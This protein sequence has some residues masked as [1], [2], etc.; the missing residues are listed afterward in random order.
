MNTSQKPQD[1]AGRAYERQ[2]ARALVMLLQGT[3]PDAVKSVR[4]NQV[5]PGASGAGHEI[6]LMLEWERQGKK[7]RCAVECKDHGRAVEKKEVGAFRSVLQDVN[8]W[9]E[10]HLLPPLG[11]IMASRNG[12]QSGAVELADYSEMVLLDIHAPGGKEWKQYLKAFRRAAGEEGEPVPKEMEISVRT[13]ERIRIEP[14]GED[15][16]KDPAFEWR[17]DTPLA[18]DPWSLLYMHRGEAGS[19]VPALLDLLR[20]MPS[21]GEP[22]GS[23]SSGEGP[24]EG[25][26]V[27]RRV[28]LEDPDG[29]LRHLTWRKGEIP[30]RRIVYTFDEVAEEAEDDM[31]YGGDR[32]DLIMQDP[33]GAI[34]L[35]IWKKEVRLLPDPIQEIRE[36]PEGEPIPDDR[37]SWKMLDRPGNGMI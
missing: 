35:G 26:S 13:N 9:R 2:V 7:R 33:V 4:M 14:A 28:V 20:R 36:A 10:Q 22:S 21:E 8:A 23:E 25:D 27:H 16:R 15:F 29:V 32:P 37:G 34:R 18:A 3:D 6:D 24:S 17:M 1:R 30:V 31:L 19:A 11:G 12:F 5:L